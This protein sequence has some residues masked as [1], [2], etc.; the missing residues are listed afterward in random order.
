MNSAAFM[1]GIGMAK[2]AVKSPAR[3]ARAR[4][5][6]EADMREAAKSGIDPRFAPAKQIHPTVAAAE[7]G[8]KFNIP[9]NPAAVVAAGEGAAPRAGNW[10]FGSKGLKGALGGVGRLGWLAAGGLGALGLWNAARTGS[11]FRHDTGL[12][13]GLLGSTAR[14]ISRNDP[15]AQFGGMEP[16]AANYWDQVTMA[17]LQREAQSQNALDRIRMLRRMGPSA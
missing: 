7:L 15:L 8:R 16:G 1:F 5:Q 14:N 9:A 11:P 12:G 2:E 17:A 10:L 3:Q 13:N 6:M 4:A